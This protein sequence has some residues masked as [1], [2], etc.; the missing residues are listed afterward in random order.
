M[1]QVVVVD[2]SLVVKW[3][4]NEED[5]VQARTLAREWANNGIRVAAP[6]LLLAE[7]T[8]TLHR[9]VVDDHMTLL[10]S[11]SLV[12]SLLSGGLE[13]HDDPRLHRRALEIASHLNQGASYDSLFLALT[14]SLDCELWTADGRFYRAA[15][16]RHPRVHWLGDV[17]ALG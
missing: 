6:H 3:L 15:R 2:T 8:N 9:R 5:F 11:I 16:D 7:L 13:L 10:E 4:I 14:E 12:E 17:E 1:N